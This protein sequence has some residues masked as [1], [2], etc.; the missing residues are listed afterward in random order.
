MEGLHVLGSCPPPYVAGMSLTRVA[1]PG[2][3]LAVELVE[4]STEPVLAVH[5]I[6]SHR[7]LWNWL[8]AEMPEL[9]LVAPDLRGR[10]DSFD[11]AGPSSVPRHAEDMVAV[12]DELGLDRVHVVGM[13]MGGFVG[14]ELATGYPDRVQ[15][16]VLVD[17]GFPMA[18]PAGMAVEDVDAVFADRLARL[19][20]AF[21]PAELAEQ[22]AQTAPMLDRDD[23]L[24]ADYLALDLAAD[25]T[26]RLSGEALK[27]DFASVF[28][29]DSPWESLT[30]PVRFS[31]AE[32]AT[33]P[34]TA[35]AYPAEAVERYAT[36]CTTVRFVPGVD[37]AGSIMTKAGAVAAADLITEA[38]S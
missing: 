20:R 32:F 28:F 31:Y 11:V 7:R 8:R 38:L 16:L 1:V 26:V 12:L 17:G 22:F 15:S 21:T 36:V 24:L 33:G 25:G 5:G 2:G 29:A 27:S 10:A 18:R 30:L 35:P 4:A 3:E 9:S 6:S 23:P 37:H 14:V 34:G 13:S 19:G